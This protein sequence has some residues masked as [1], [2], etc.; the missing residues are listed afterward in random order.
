VMVA[1]STQCY[2]SAGQSGRHWMDHSHGGGC[3]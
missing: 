2:G 3:W 1:L